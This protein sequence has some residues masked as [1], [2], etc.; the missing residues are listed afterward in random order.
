L[1]EL[2]VVIAIIAILAAILFPVFATAR[3]KARQT[4]C[5]SN[6]KQ[7]GLAFI[8]Y[9]QDYDEKTLVVQYPQSGTA[10]CAVWSPGIMLAPYLKAIG[11]WIC[12]SDTVVSQA[13]FNNCM[14]AS[15]NCFTQVSY[16]YNAYMMM[17]WQAG[18]PY[19]A[20]VAGTSNDLCGAQTPA[21]MSQLTTPASDGLFFADRSQWGGWLFWGAGNGLYFV[22]GLNNNNYQGEQ[23]TGPTP[24]HNAGGNVLYADGHVK[25]LTGTYLGSQQVLENVS[26]SNSARGFGSSTPTLFHE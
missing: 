7:I 5:A 12:P 16:G 11:I 17:Q 24:G 3:E 9:C 6:E 8:Q 18:N 14:P 20:I 2:L 4:S 26:G 13:N 1:I 15:Y 10:T 25:W 22:E 23:P 19:N 21:Q